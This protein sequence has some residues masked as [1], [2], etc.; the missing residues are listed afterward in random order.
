MIITRRQLRKIIKEE[1]SRTLR[2]G[3][4][5]DVAT[6][7]DTHALEPKT[8]LLQEDPKRDNA[9]DAVGGAKSALSQIHGGWWSYVKDF[10]LDHTNDKKKLAAALNILTQ[11]YGEISKLPPLP[12]G[13][14]QDMRITRRQLRKIIKEELSRALNEDVDITI[15]NVKATVDEASDGSMI[16][17]SRGSGEQDL[18][19]RVSKDKW[20]TQ[21]K[22]LN[23]GITSTEKTSLLT[24]RSKRY[25]HDIVS[26]AS[27]ATGG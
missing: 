26:W 6:I 19:Y 2:E 7:S 5:D 16:T 4:E 10:A 24:E 8:R 21:Y 9:T 25:A 18:F 11:I 27:V 13:R 15:D 20:T 3:V 22:I 17:A 1:L 14:E 23:L 12:E